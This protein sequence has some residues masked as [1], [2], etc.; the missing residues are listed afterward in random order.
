MLVG[1]RRQDDLLLRDGCVPPAM[2][3]CLGSTDYGLGWV[4][5][6]A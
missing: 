1:K 3:R 5:E 2:P 4:N 6:L